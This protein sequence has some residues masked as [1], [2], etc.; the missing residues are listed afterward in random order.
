M[1]PLLLSHH[2]HALYILSLTFASAHTASL[3]HL[4][5]LPPLL[6]ASAR[7][8]VA[9]LLLENVSVTYQN[10]GPLLSW[11]CRFMSSTRLFL[12]SASSSL[13][14]LSGASNKSNIL[15]S[16]YALAI[17]LWKM[18]LWHEPCVSLARTRA[19]GRMAAN[20]LWR[21]AFEG[22]NLSSVMPLNLPSLFIM[23]LR[24]RARAIRRRAL[25][26]L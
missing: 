7:A 12:F 17:W 25:Q 23:P 6:P 22:N 2:T 16:S 21:R 9:C 14:Q 1:Q 11:P 3:A 13:Y 18:Y 15:A 26:P 24:T 8:C 4:C 20:I 10:T 19:A 5:Y